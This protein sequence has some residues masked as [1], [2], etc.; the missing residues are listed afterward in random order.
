MPH[1]ASARGHP[2]ITIGRLI[3]DMNFSCNG[4]TIWLEIA[5]QL[6]LDEQY[7]QYPKLQIW[8]LIS[9]PVT[10]FYIWTGSE[11][12]LNS[13]MCSTGTWTNVTDSSDVYQCSLEE[14]A[15]VSFQHGDLI[16]LILP[17]LKDAKFLL[18]FTA[19]SGPT[20]YIYFQE[21]GTK[22]K[23]VATENAQPQ[24]TLGIRSM[25][26]DEPDVSSSSPMLPTSQPAIKGTK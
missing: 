23:Q 9:V 24:L 11:V 14:N 6:Q 21:N 16:A 19:E 12:V 10:S 3:P 8:R 18:Y 5:G 1:N 13:S 22:W 20:N 15:Y 17:P 2:N 26:T 4:E 25:S 7:S